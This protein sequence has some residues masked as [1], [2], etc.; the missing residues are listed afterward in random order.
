MKRS[1]T[2]KT[3]KQ[4]KLWTIFDFFGCRMTT[5]CKVYLFLLNFRLFSSFSMKKKIIFWFFSVGSQ[6]LIS[7]LLLHLLCICFIFLLHWC[8][9]L[10]IMCNVK[11]T[12]KVTTFLR[13]FIFLPY[14]TNLLCC[15]SPL[16]GCFALRSTLYFFYFCFR[17]MFYSESHEHR[18]EHQ[19]RNKFSTVFHSSTIFNCFS[20]SYWYFAII[21]TFLLLYFC[22]R[23]MFCSEIH[24]YHEEHRKGN[25]LLCCIDVLLSDSWA[26]WRTPKR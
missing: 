20:L 22:V 12:K 3:L 25:N 15:I 9:A 21:F 5:V 11:N 24:E 2:G 23:S 13:F 4:R 1:K 18:E 17:L 19:K 10:R 14:L 26:S 6:V 8:F 7:I 16:E